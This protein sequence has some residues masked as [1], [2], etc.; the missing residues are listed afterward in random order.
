MKQDYSPPEISK[1]TPATIPSGNAKII[2]KIASQ[3]CDL[4]S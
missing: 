3:I 4:L 1:N 2:E